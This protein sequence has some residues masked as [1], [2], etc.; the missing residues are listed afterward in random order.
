[1]NEV[2][3]DGIAMRKRGK[4]KRRVMWSAGPDHTWSFDGQDKLMPYGNCWLMIGLA[5]HSCVDVTSGYLVW[6]RVDVTTLRTQTQRT[7]SFQYT[8]Q[9]L[10]Q[11]W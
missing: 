6:L 2:N 7:T 4:L 8:R 9:M 3:P 5:V 10:R 1:M 11:Y